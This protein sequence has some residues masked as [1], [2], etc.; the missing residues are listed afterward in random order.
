MTT[1]KETTFT[2][3]GSKTGQSIFSLTKRM[4]KEV[5]G[6]QLLQD[7]FLSGNSL[8]QLL[9]WGFL[10][11]LNLVRIRVVSQRLRVPEIKQLLCLEIKAPHSVAFLPDKINY[12]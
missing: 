2:I 3:D 7:R 10:F 6:H 5:L 1:T 12:L 4:V 11:R 8:N 9:V